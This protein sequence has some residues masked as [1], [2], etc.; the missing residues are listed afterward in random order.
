MIKEVPGPERVVEV[1]KE[2]PIYSH[3]PSAAAATPPQPSPGQGPAAGG[4]AGAART[5]TLHTPSRRAAPLLP[6]PRAMGSAAKNS[7]ASSAA[8]GSAAAAA[9]AEGVP[10][11]LSSS[12]S[13]PMVAKH[14]SYRSAFE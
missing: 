2:V 4:A 10:P 14:S 7:A 12:R 1:I 5:A 13:S 6:V 8:A 11:Q 3:S 9:V